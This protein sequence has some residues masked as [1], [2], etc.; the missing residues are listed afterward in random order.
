MFWY[1]HERRT[2]GRGYLIENCYV[3]RRRKRP[4]RS[5]KANATNLKRPSM[6]DG[7]FGWRQR[8]FVERS[9][10]SSTYWADLA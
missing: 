8:A 7:P 1:M 4:V 10:V 9:S 5:L 3:R 2:D 6:V